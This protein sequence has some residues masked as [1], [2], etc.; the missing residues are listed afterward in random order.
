LIDSTFTLLFQD[1]NSGLE[2][3]DRRT[4]KFIAAT[5]KDG[6]LYMNIGDMFQRMSNGFY[7]SAKHRVI[8]YDGRDGG[9][10]EQVVSRYSLPHFISPA[11]DGVIEPQPSC[12]A[13]D[14]KQV[15]ESVTFSSEAQ[16]ILSAV[17]TLA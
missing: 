15:Y 17:N 11:M 9:A 12:V 16:R 10:G 8:V 1:S 14:G 2:F 4:G 5:P 6:V 7:P 13:R 3:E